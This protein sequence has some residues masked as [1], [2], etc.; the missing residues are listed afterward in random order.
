MVRDSGHL[1][2][3]EADYA[4]AAALGLRTIRESIGW[5]LTERRGAGREARLRLHAADRFARAA[6]RHG[7]QV[8]W[9]LMHYGTPADVEPAR[10]CLLRPLRALRR[11]RSRAPCAPLL[12]HAAG[13]HADQRDQLPRLGG[14][15]DPADPA[16]CR[17]A[18]GSRD[19]SSARQRL[20]R[21][22]PAGARRAARRCEAIRAEDPRARFLHVEPVVHVVAPRESPELAERA[23]RVA[24]LPVADLGPARRA[25]AARTRRPCRRARPD[26]RQPLPQRP[27]GG[28]HRAAART[29]TCATRAARRSRR[30]C[31]R[32]GSAT[33]GRSS[34]A[35]TS[36]VGERP[37]A[38]ARRDRRRGRPGARRRRTGAGPVPLPGGRPPRLGRRATGTTAAS[39]TSPTRRLHERD[40]DAAPRPARRLNPAYARALQTLRSSACRVPPI[41]RNCHVSSDRLLPPALGLRLPAAA[42]P[43]VA[44]GAAL[45]RASSSRSR[46]TTTAPPHLERIDAGAERRRCCAPHTPV[47]APRLPR[48]PAVGAASRCSPT[49]CAEQPIDDYVVWFYT[50]MALPLLAELHAARRRLRLHGRAVRVQGRAAPAAASARP[51]C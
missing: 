22:V 1:D 9:S 27:V 19:G 34:V 20:R 21:Q 11:A 36:H 24:R 41:D 39:G 38:L 8:L 37:R 10:R 23:E 17:R 40:S 29:G 48:R 18:T 51:R 46:C 6:Q 14:R 32:P 12:R 26:R 33:A 16:V 3:L 44:A 49:T 2:H 31:R 7:L 25:T 4:G 42:A 43:A 45:P 30:C 47:D 50:P 35:E 13:L 15:R 5:R 28:R